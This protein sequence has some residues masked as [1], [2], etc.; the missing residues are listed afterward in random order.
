METDRELGWDDSIKNDSSFVE[1]PPGDYNFTID[2]FKRSR[3]KGGN[4]IP[5][6]NMAIVY[7]NIHTKDGDAVQIRENFILHTKLEWKLSELFCAVGLKK[8]GEELRMNWNAL[9]GL[10]GK[11]QISLDPDQN[12]PTK[13]YNHIKKLYPK[14]AGNGYT[15]G[16]F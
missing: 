9:P 5:A 15:A 16:S 10:T 11:C 13:K 2:H 1:L 4:S 8:K 6:S 14:E 3:S 12:D 7:F